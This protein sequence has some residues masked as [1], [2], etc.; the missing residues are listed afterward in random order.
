MCIRDRRCTLLVRSL[1]VTHGLTRRCSFSDVATVQVYHPRRAFSLITLDDVRA[2]A[3]EWGLPR[4]RFERSDFKV[5]HNMTRLTCQ[6]P[7]AVMIIDAFM[8]VAKTAGQK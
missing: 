4:I 2:V 6:V 7:A 3:T 5:P 1:S 8:N